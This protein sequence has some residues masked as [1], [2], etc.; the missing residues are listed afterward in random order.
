MLTSLQ[1]KSSPHPSPDLSIHV[2]SCPSDRILGVHCVTLNM[3]ILEFFSSLPTKWFF[4]YCCGWEW[5]YLVTWV[6]L[7]LL[8]FLSPLTHV[9]KTHVCYPI[10]LLPSFQ[11]L[12]L[13]RPQ[14]LPWM[15]GSFCFWSLSNKHFSFHTTT[16]AT[17][18]KMLAYSDTFPA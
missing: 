13:S 18:K 9:C 11:P 17:F 1:P 16:I 7:A 6:S 3:N 14:F 5:P 2:W 4:L 10:P 8:F 15:M 12:P